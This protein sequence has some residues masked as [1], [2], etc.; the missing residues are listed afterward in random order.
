[1]PAAFQLFQQH[2]RLYS[3]SSEVQNNHTNTPHSDRRHDRAGKQNQQLQ[4]QL[5]LASD[6][7]ASLKGAVAGTWQDSFVQ[8]KNRHAGRGNQQR[9][10]Q[11]QPG[12]LQNRRQQQQQRQQQL[13]AKL[14]AAAYN[15][16]QAF[17]AAAAARSQ[18][19]TAEEQRCLQQ[20]AADTLAQLSTASLDAVQA[21]L[22][23]Y[24]TKRFVLQEQQL[25]QLLQHLAVNVDACTPRHA[26]AAV[27]A[28]QTAAEAAAAA[29]AAAGNSRQQVGTQQQQQVMLQRYHAQ[30]QPLVVRSLQ[31]VTEQLQQHPT[32][33]HPAAAA[34]AVSSATLTYMLTMHERIGLLPLPQQEMQLLL[35]HATATADQYSLLQ[36]LRVLYHSK[37][38][39]LPLQSIQH[40]PLLDRALQLLLQNLQQQQQ[41]Q[42]SAGVDAATGPTNGSS[43]KA[44]AAVL[45]AFENAGVVIPQPALQQLA[46]HIAANASACEPRHAFRT[47]RSAAFAGLQLQQ[48]QLQPLVA[49]VLQQQTS[50]KQKARATLLGLLKAVSHMGVQLQ[51][52]QLEEVVSRLLALAPAG[53]MPTDEAAAVTKAVACMGMQLPRHLLRPLLRPLQ[54]GVRQGDQLQLLPQ[55]LTA[56][57]RMGVELPEATE[58]APLLKAAKLALKAEAQAAARVAAQAK[59][60]RQQQQ[61]KQREWLPAPLIADLVR[62]LQHTRAQFPTFFALPLTDAFLQQQPAAKDIAKYWTAFG[63]MDLAVDLRQATAILQQLLQPDQLRDL[64]SSEVGSILWG[65]ASMGYSLE[66]GVLEVLVQQQLAQPK[67]FVAH[68]Y[69]QT[70]WAITNMGASPRL[71]S[72]LHWLQQQRLAPV[73]PQM[74][75]QLL[76]QIHNEL[77]S[78]ASQQ[79]QQHNSSHGSATCATAGPA[80]MYWQLSLAAWATAV[81]NA[82][83]CQPQILQMCQLLAVPQAWQM[84]RMT[85]LVQ[86]SWV[87][88]WLCRYQWSDAGGLA[89]CL[90]QQQLA[91]IKN[92]RQ[93]QV[94]HVVAAASQKGLSSSSSSK[95]EGSVFAQQQQQQ[96]PDVALGDAADD[97]QAWCLGSEDEDSSSSSSRSS[98]GYLQQEQMLPKRQQQQQRQQPEGASVSQIELRDALQSLPCIASARLEALTDDSMF[99][100]DVE[101]VTVDG[102]RLAVE[103]DGPYHYAQ[104]VA[105]SNETRAPVAAATGEEPAAAAAA[106]AAAELNGLTEADSQAAAAAVRTA[107]SAAAEANA[108]AQGLRSVP[109]LSIALPA[110]FKA[111]NQ[112]YSSIVLKRTALFRDAA[113][114]A[115]GYIVVCVPFYQWASREPNVQRWQLQRLVDAALAAASSA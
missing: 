91:D 93:R 112:D 37:L 63:A 111:N 65:F 88:M 72:D 30:L 33:K 66:P 71:G 109:P 57:S 52:Q 40:Q 7:A 95:V 70:L 9:Q 15:L 25:Q 113:L 77:A 26:V 11:Q 103:F 42:M 84:L 36:A 8:H 87:H 100:I 110:A 83:S 61:V 97:M 43:I 47:I 28:V 108:V 3:S 41:Q 21:L 20:A 35:Q 44:A 50:D 98:M 45:H 49:C 24:G 1:V 96:Q 31:H 10:Q 79:Q 14:E 38:S 64:T 114:Q 16:P 104:H 81:C 34:A 76:Q 18:G 90:S 78:K 94:Q 6:A 2:A 46:A 85:E 101:A 80:A 54:R 58:M 106:A 12:L 13:A 68:S 73:Q 39:Q 74:L 89:T 107:R 56:V 4:Q 69:T 27:A 67:R 23:A 5:G 59:H 86:L 19:N 82:V 53:G 60:S 75:Q 32:S 55:L 48:D 29:A 99:S 22:Y 115:R 17:K 51:Q 102:Q 62:S 92:A 105:F